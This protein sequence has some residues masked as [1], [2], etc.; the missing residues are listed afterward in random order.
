MRSRALGLLALALAGCGTTM[1]AH[2]II[3]QGG[4]AHARPVA[5]FL[6]G[7]RPPSNYAEVALVQANGR[8]DHNDPAHALDGLRQEAA[9]LGCDAVVAAR[10]DVGTNQTAAVGVAVRWAPGDP[11]D[12]APAR[13]PWA[14]A[15]PGAPPAAPSATQ[16][17]WSVPPD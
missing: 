11:P 15:A 17:P 16:A 14:P 9:S 7:Q 3:G 8:G 1:T 5:V 4:P 12:A 13:A 6:A 10:V 2:A